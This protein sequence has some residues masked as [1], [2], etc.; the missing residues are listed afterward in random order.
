MPIHGAQHRR[1]S[2]TSSMGNI[3]K[4]GS[5]YK[6]STAPTRP[7]TN[8]LGT[9]TNLKAYGYGSVMWAEMQEKQKKKEAEGSDKLGLM[10]LKNGKWR[11]AFDLFDKAVDLASN[12]A[13]RRDRNSSNT[14]NVLAYRIHRT[15][16]LIKLGEVEVAVRELETVLRMDPR[17]YTAQHILA[18]LFLRYVPKDATYLDN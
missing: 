6:A 16:A 1:H 3:I 13:D 12:I 15:E 5:E 11:E 7:A 18:V 2:S 10:Q 17:S 9:G 8:T 14:S 4:N